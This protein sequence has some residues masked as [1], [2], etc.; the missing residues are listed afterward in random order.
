MSP[1]RGLAQEVDLNTWGDFHFA[2]VSP[3]TH[4][5]EFSVSEGMCPLFFD[6]GDL[7]EGIV[8]DH[9]HQSAGGAPTSATEVVSSLA[10]RERLTVLMEEI[11]ANRHHPIFVTHTVPDLDAVA[12]V[13]AALSVWRNMPGL[14][15]KLVDY[16]TAKDCGEGV[17]HDLLSSIGLFFAVFVEAAEDDRERMILGLRLLEIFNS[18]VTDGWILP[19]RTNLSDLSA[20]RDACPNVLERFRRH[21]QQ[22]QALEARASSFPVEVLSDDGAI[23]PCT[24]CLLCFDHT[25]PYVVGFKEYFRSLR[26]E[27]GTFRYDLLLVFSQE[28][29]RCRG[30]ISV[31]PESGLRLRGLGGLLDAA[32][33]EKSQ[34]RDMHRDEWSAQEQ[35]TARQR[36]LLGDG[37]PTLIRNTASPRKGYGNADPWYDGRGHGWTIVDAPHSGTVLS[38]DEICEV[39]KRFAREDK[40]STTDLVE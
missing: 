22:L 32:E 25:Q 28:H 14:D 1:G 27:D 23:L 40:E 15:K 26:E 24:G 10:G 9:H 33:T 29:S 2:F 36:G 20:L 39:L 34:M 3:G 18:A 6:V 30:V 21:V 19:G 16:I 35:E 4:P 5:A 12:A 38:K 11:R 13:Y 31:R 7:N 17:D 37:E 8:F